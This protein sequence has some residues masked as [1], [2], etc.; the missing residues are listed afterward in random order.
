M[1]ITG[2]GGSESEAR[3]LEGRLLFHDG[4]RPWF[5]LKLDQPQCRQTSTE[6]VRVDDEK[7]LEVLRGCRVKSQ[8]VLLFAVTGL[9]V[10]QV[11][12]QVES[13]GKCVRHAPFP[14][15]S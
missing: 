13:V 5:E 1:S 14:D 6:L 15:F 3:T 2:T 9:D 10:R 11:V 12:Q 8:G 7:P 4:I